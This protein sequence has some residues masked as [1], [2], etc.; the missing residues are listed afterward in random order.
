[1]ARI[2]I[3]IIFIWVIYIAGVV[4]KWRF[5]VFAVGLQMAIKVN[6]VPVSQFQSNGR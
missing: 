5:G 2:G 4:A 6:L 3:R 1:M